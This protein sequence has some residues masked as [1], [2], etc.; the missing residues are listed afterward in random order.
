MSPRSRRRTKKKR[1]RLK[2]ICCRIENENVKKEK[3]MGTCTLN[4]RDFFH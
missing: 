1:R 4:W 2:K 3:N